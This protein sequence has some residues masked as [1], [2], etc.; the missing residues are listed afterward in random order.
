MASDKKLEA[1]AVRTAFL[2]AI[3]KWIGEWRPL[4]VGPEFSSCLSP[5][6][7]YPSFVQ[8]APVTYVICAWPQWTVELELLA[9]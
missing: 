1:L 7:S 9:W 6:S 2:R 3:I 4:Q 5:H 8:L